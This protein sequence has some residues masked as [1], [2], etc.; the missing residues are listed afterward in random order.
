MSSLN[1]EWNDVVS[2]NPVSKSM[3]QIRK[4]VFVF[5]R[6]SMLMLLIFLIRKLQTWTA[7]FQ[8]STTHGKLKSYQNTV[9]KIM[10]QS[11][12]WPSENSWKA[13][14]LTQNQFQWY[15]IGNIKLVCSFFHIDWYNHVWEMKPIE[16]IY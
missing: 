5:L 15:Y 2:S 1:E 11:F 10:L 3:S 7:V 8:L 6:K 12:F 13:K 9:L 4:P 14:V 16:E